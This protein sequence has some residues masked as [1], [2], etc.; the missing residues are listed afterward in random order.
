MARRLKQPQ[1]VN[2]LV[3][4]ATT[5]RYYNNYFFESDG[6]IQII[7]FFAWDELTRLPMSNGLVYFMASILADELFD[8]DSHFEFTGC[9]NDFWLNKTEIDKAMRFAFICDECMSS[10]RRKSRILDD[11]R[12][13]LDLVHDASRDNRDIVEFW[14][15]QQAKAPFDVFLCHNSADKESVRGIAKKLKRKGIRC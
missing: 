4:I 1:F 3:V 2:S 8:I 12:V 6:P 13:M 11:V 15:G 9:V 7:S 14:Q 5:K 10:R